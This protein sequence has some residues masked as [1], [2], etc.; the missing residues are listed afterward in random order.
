VT[1]SGT[2]P[3]VTFT[4]AGARYALPVRRV[5]EVTT[6]VPVT[7]VPGASSRLLGVTAWRGRTI[8]VL[9]PRPN[10]KRDPREPDVVSRIL[11]VG[12]PSPFGVRI[13]D[14]GRVLR[15]S[16][17]RPLEPGD[18]EANAAGPDLVRTADGLVRLLD[19]E[20][21]LGDVRT[22]IGESP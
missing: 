7:R 19:P 12:H 3:I 21:V 10:L 16:D 11:V 6:A 22:L 15:A 2:D 17:L 13:D 4:L 1:R 20:E 14:P 9:D 8:P 18:P 5:V